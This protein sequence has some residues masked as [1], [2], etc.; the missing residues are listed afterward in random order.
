M[1]QKGGEKMET[2]TVRSF[3]RAD[4]SHAVP[5]GR[6]ALVRLGG[7][8]FDRA[9]FAPGWRWSDGG[10]SGSCEE[11]HLGVLLAGRMR[12]RMDDGTEIEARSGDV[13]LVPP[14]HDAWVVGDEECVALDIRALQPRPP[15]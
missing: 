6:I 15:R 9:V 7:L 5:G 3:D 11:R 14:G 4:A 12:F 8:A 13:Y 10:G 2:P 1:R